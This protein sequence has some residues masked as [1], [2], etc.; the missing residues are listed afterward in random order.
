[1]YKNDLYTK[2]VD[3]YARLVY[4]DESLQAWGGLFICR[5]LHSQDAGRG[6]VQ[7]QM[8]ESADSAEGFFL[9]VQKNVL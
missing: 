9:R 5:K 4:I 3:N 8:R 6:G 7:R 2:T 1:M